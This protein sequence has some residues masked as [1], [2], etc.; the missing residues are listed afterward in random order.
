MTSETN[1]LKARLSTLSDSLD[2][3]ETQ[4]A[5]L[6]AQTLPETVVG[7]E[8]IQQAKLQ[9]V[10]P[11]LVYDLVF[12]YLKSKGIDPKTHPVYGELERV[13]QYFQK[14]ANAEDASKRRLVTDKDAANRF[15][16][17]AI[18]QATYGQD[19]RPPGE[20]AGPSQ[21]AAPVPVKIT[22]KMAARAEYEKELKELGSDDEED[23]LE[24][25]DEEPIQEGWDVV[26]MKERR[27]GKKGKGKEKAQE[28]TQDGSEAPQA[29]SKRRRPPMDPFAGYGDDD[30]PSTQEAPAPVE[31][32]KKVKK[33]K[34]AASLSAGVDDP[35]PSQTNSTPG[36][37]KKAKKAKQKGPMIPTAR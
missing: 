26:D 9:T 11:Y 36:K 7:L 12:I 24:V 16:K 15:I 20:E 23:G 8:T 25:F 29:G 6:L 34:S 28:D 4:L 18:A 35:S 27:D 22:A 31:K 1:R 19:K 21:S 3:L 17:H 2:D 5:P 10:L 37:A 13:R 33:S 30:A 14:I 32:K